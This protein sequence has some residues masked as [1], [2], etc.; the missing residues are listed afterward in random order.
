MN[1]PSRVTTSKANIHTGDTLCLTCEVNYYYITENEHAIEAV[2]KLQSIVKDPNSMIA[3]DIETTGFSPFTD[4]ILLAQIGTVYNDQYIFDMRKI[5]YNIILPLL[6]T[7]CWKI[8]HNIKFDAKF[9]KV[10][11]GISIERMY[12]TMLA[13]MIIRGED[14]GGFA[15]DAILKKRFD[16]ELILIRKDLMGGSNFSEE[17]KTK[18]AKKKMQQSFLNMDKDTDFDPGQLAYAAHDVAKDT[19]FQLVTWQLSRLQIPCPSTLYDHQVTSASEP[20]V[21]EQYEELFPP[22]MTLWDTACLEF[23]FLEV[24]IEL[25]LDGIGFDVDKHSEVMQLVEKDYK[26]YKSDFL[27]CMSNDA[28]QNTLFGYAAINPDSPAQ[29]KDALNSLGLYVESTGADILD[30]TI[31]ALEEG[32]NQHNALKNLIGYRKTSKLISTYGKPLMQQVNPETG[33]LHYNIKQILNTGRISTSKPNLQNMPA[34]IDWKITLEESKNP[35]TVK[36]LADRDGLRECF[37][38]KEGYTFLIYDY[39]AQ[40]MRIAAHITRDPAL[41]TAFK[42]GKDLHSF[43]ASEMYHE[44]YERL[45]ALAKYDD[46]MEPVEVRKQKDDIISKFNV[47]EAEIIGLHKIAKKQRGAGK[48]L[49]FGSLYGSG[50]RNVSETLHI[51]IEDAQ[52]IQSRYWKVYSVMKDAME[53]YGFL[54]N[55]YGYSNTIM[56][57]RR[58]Y[59]FLKE[60]INWIKAEISP[61]GVERRIVDMKMHWLLEKGPVT[62][63]NMRSMKDKVISRLESEIARQAGNH[64]IQGTA[65]DMTKLAAIDIRNAIKA[66][67]FDAKLVGLIHDEV[68]VEVIDSQAAEVEKIVIEKMNRAESFYCPTVKAAVEGKESPHWL[69]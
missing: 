59:T 47:E 20:R 6:I 17:N 12:D 57:R 31:K 9:A 39:S 69:K 67:E 56:G 45:H 5:D 55:K 61:S 3:F 11:W 19:M 66:G 54:A 2:R 28:S 8:G 7:S 30:N 35:I 58:Y 15:L 68:I 27:S 25:E 23:K 63:K 13:E 65:A 53:R 50:V 33:R 64:H 29:I 43:A 16:R 37:I 48:T 18:T 62:A 24:V 60:R 40:E 34:N 1:F 14:K 38:A 21:R 26:E 51:P 44:D 49:N 36:K 41:H 46:S 32:S 4:E 22:T 52:D 42:E 10:K